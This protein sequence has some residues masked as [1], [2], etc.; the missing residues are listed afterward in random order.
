MEL[1]FGDILLGMF[2]PN[3]KK[4]DIPDSLWLPPEIRRRIEDGNNVGDNRS[5][6]RRLEDALESLLQRIN[7][8]ESVL[9]N[10]GI[11]ERLDRLESVHAIDFSPSHTLNHNPHISRR[12]A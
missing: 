5:V 7:H 11:D 4:S 6:R 1:V 9:E 3:L 2:S 12:G 10:M 8:V